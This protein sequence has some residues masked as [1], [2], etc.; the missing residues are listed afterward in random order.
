MNCA[1]CVFTII[2]KQTPSVLVPKD[3]EQ[4]CYFWYYDTYKHEQEK[5]AKSADDC[6]KKLRVWAKKAK[7]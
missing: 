3:F 4:I 6:V 2:H 1:C 7:K 5:D